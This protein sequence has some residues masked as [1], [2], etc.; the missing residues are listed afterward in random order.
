MVVVVAGDVVRLDEPA[1]LEAFKVVV[2]KGTEFQVMQALAQIGRMA[3]RDTAWIRADAVRIM[4]AGRVAQ[5]WT[6]QFQGV[7]AYAA[8]KGWLSDDGSEVRA[9]IEWASPGP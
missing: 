9:H 7:L 8:T 1:N 3:D 5:D 2:E 6:E 4:A